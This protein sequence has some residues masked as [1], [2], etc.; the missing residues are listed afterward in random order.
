MRNQSGNEGTFM[1]LQHIHYIVYSLQGD[2][3]LLRFC[4]SRIK[5]V[6][7]GDIFNCVKNCRLEINREVY[8]TSE[9]VQRSKMNMPAEYFQNNSLN[10]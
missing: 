8:T 4:S 2:G 7:F 3:E 9:C 1:D 10:K 6:G 5:N